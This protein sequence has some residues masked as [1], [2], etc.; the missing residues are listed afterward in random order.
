MQ[1][2]KSMPSIR[3]RETSLC[4]YCTSVC[5]TQQGL[6]THIT[7]LHKDQ[8]MPTAFTKPI[9]LTTLQE[10]KEPISDLV[11][12]TVV[13]QAPQKRR[14]GRKVGSKNKPKVISLAC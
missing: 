14:R 2:G 11:C 3:A 6:R 10:E 12:E 8:P 7:R 9:S 1:K 13:E 5:K 4:P